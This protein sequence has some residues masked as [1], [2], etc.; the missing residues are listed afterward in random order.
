MVHSTCLE[1][2]RNTGKIT[3]VWPDL[4]N[5]F[6]KFIESPRQEDFETTYINVKPLDRLQLDALISLALLMP[7]PSGSWAMASRSERRRSKT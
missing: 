2:D 5:D 4:S 7:T 3:A 1:K 6:M